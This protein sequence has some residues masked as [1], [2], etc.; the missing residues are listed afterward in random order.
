LSGVAL[1][2]DPSDFHLL[3]SYNYRHKPL[4]PGNSLAVVNNAA[5][6]MGGQVSYFNLIYIPFGIYL[7]VVLP[8][9]MA[10]LFLVFVEPP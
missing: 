10:V 3:S 8:D 2:C 4:A 7:G 9:H 1:N 5:I 6:N